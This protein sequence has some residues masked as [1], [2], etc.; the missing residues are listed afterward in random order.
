M[1]RKATINDVDFILSVYHT[2]TIWQD[3]SD[4]NTPPLTKEMLITFISSGYAVLLIPDDIGVFTFHPWNSITYA[5]HS[6]VLPK[7]RGVKALDGARQAGFWMFENTLCQKIVTLVPA[8]NYKARALAHAGGMLKEGIIT[9]SLL[10]KGERIDQYL[11]G[12]TKE[13]ARWD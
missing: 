5:M 12:I 2:D 11:Y 3:S 13:A 7:Y 10:K 4:D 6:A 8:N 9:K 1:I